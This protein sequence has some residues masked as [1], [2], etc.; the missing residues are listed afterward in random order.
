M[1]GSA[2]IS[3]WIAPGEI[4]LEAPSDFGVGAPLTAKFGD[5]SVGSGADPPA[6][7]QDVMQRAVE[8]SVAA[9]VEP[10]TLN[11]STACRY[12]AGAG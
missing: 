5:V 8:V 9:T 3:R 1:S 6:G 11:P 7:E 10:V 12:W 4:A 2:L